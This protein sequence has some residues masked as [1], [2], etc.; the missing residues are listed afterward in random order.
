MDAS[1]SEN[2]ECQSE[3]PWSVQE[4]A[5]Q[6]QTVNYTILGTGSVDNLEFSM[7]LDNKDQTVYLALSHIETNGSKFHRIL[8]GLGFSQDNLMISFHTITKKNR[9]L[10]QFS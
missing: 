7:I 6:L 4:A 5:D 10:Y 3:Q 8:Q 2:A 1:A 9:E